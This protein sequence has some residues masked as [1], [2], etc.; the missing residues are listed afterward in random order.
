MGAELRQVAQGCQYRTLSY[1]TYDINGYRFRTAAHERKRHN[2]KTINS[3]VVTVGEDGIEY[4]GIIEEIIELSFGSSKPLK[5]VLFKCHW[6]HPIR[7][8]RRNPNIGLVE[9]KR[10]SV[11]LG[12]EPFIVASQATQVYYVPYPCKTMTSL[13]DWDVVYKVPPRTKLPTPNDEDYNTDLNTNIDEFFQE[14]GLLGNFEIVIGHED[15]HSGNTEIEVEEVANEKDLELLNRLNIDSDS[16]DDIPPNVLHVDDIFDIHDSDYD[17]S[18][19]D[20]VVP[21]E[22]DPN[23]MFCII[24]ILYFSFDIS[25]C[26]IVNTNLLYWISLQEK[27]CNEEQ[28]W[29]GHKTNKG[30]HSG[31]RC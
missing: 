26:F 21:A 22:G 5:I 10:T 7:G 15:Y 3:G 29:Q 8:V 11:L 12:N 28:S 14:D 24:D 25:V 16:E 27:A 4:Y 13:V 6:F 17:L 9:V 31:C 23:C 19:Y 20:I 30:C 1:N 2:A 18:D